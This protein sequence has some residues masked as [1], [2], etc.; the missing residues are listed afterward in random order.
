[1]TSGPPSTLY[2]AC[3][4]RPKPRDAIVP[5]TLTPTPWFRDDDLADAVQIRNSGQHT[6]LRS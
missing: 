5:N 4:A 2:D 6:H 1:M 3:G